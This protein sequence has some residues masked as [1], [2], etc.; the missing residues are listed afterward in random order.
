MKQAI[1][2]ES[3]IRELFKEM[4]GGKNPFSDSKLPSK[5]S[6]V[7]DPSA[8]L[9]DPGNPNYRPNSYE[10]LQVS[11]S[12]LF[13]DFPEEKIPDVYTKISRFIQKM[14]P[15]NQK[16]NSNK[17]KKDSDMKNKNNSVAEALI[18]AQV[19]KIISETLS[20]APTGRPRGRPPGSGRSGGRQAGAKGEYNT[21]AGGRGAGFEDIA[22][23]LGV[24]TGTAHLDL[25]KGL[26][27]VRSGAWMYAT[28]PAEM[29][30][31]KVVGQKFLNKLEDKA[32]KAWEQNPVKDTGTTFFN[33][34]DI[35]VLSSD[36]GVA[37]GIQRFCDEWLSDPENYE[38][39]D[40]M[41]SPEEIEEFR[42]NPDSV[43][44]LPSFV[45]V[46]LV[47]YL[48]NN[49]DLLDRLRTFSESQ[50]Y[51]SLMTQLKNKYKNV[52]KN[53]SQQAAKDALRALSAMRPD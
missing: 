26:D 15:D 44:T 35:R 27:K 4:L 32:L 22:S 50:E 25:G 46:F 9:T 18:R 16:Q 5:I 38:S 33:S 17:E 48:R 11:L 14:N 10:E 13:D 51:T 7:T 52:D 19:R 29:G 6:G 23:A 28:S 45:Y 37:N 3:A 31:F 43:V 20:E 41:V 1:V 53:Q 8:I 12:H 40:D 21:V 2:K 36:Q 39:E 30:Q 42:M 24:S 34:E 47:D 49:F